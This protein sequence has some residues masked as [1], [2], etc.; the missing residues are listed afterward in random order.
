MPWRA[1]EGTLALNQLSINTLYYCYETTKSRQSSQE[2]LDFG[3]G[4]LCRG[5]EVGRKGPEPFAVHV[6]DRARK[7]MAYAI[8]CKALTGGKGLG[9]ITLKLGSLV[10]VVHNQCVPESQ[11]E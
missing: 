5:R 6:E 10:L 7:G 2:C 8:C 4:D 9:Q 3:E 1:K 11:R